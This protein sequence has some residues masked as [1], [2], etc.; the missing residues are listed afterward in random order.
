MCAQARSHLPQSNLGS[1]P[2]APAI[3]PALTPPPPL[4]THT[5]AHIHPHFLPLLKRIFPNFFLDF[6][7]GG[8][9]V[10]RTH[11]QA[12]AHSLT[13]PVLFLPLSGRYCFQMFPHIRVKTVSIMFDHTHTHTHT[14]TQS[15][16]PLLT[17]FL[18]LTLTY[19]HTHNTHTCTHARTHARTHSL[20]HTPTHSHTYI[21]RA[22]THAH[23]HTIRSLS[24]THRLLFISDA[25]CIVSY[26]IS[27]LFA[28]F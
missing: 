15:L 27:V 8:A 3:C 26:V 14:H 17:L 9:A 22:H 24:H 28:L 4:Q 10:T 18:P 12:D 25:T 13:P 2:S 6:M 16:T 5:H 20:T 23:A 1:T 19:K 21:H 7:G 11:T